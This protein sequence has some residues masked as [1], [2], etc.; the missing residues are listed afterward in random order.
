M[1]RADFFISRSGNLR[2]FTVCGHAAQNVC[3]MQGKLICAAV[4]SAAYCVANTLGRLPDVSPKIQVTGGKMRLRLSREDEE[5]PVCA[6]L[7]K[8]FL[9]HMRQLRR[10]YPERICEPIYRCGLRTARG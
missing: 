6:A 7:I 5:N 8:G 3:D 9:A 2:G 10:Q 1:I 4:S